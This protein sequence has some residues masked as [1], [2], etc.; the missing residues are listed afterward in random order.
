ML[1]GPGIIL[2]IFLTKFST[3]SRVKQEVK[4]SC[5]SYTTIQYKIQD[6]KAQPTPTPSVFS[7]YVLNI[8]LL[9]WVCAESEAFSELK[10]T[11][12]YGRNRV[13]K[14][15]WKIFSEIPGGSQ[16]DFSCLKSSFIF[17]FFAMSKETLH[18]SS[19]CHLLLWLT[20]D[21]PLWLL[22]D[23]S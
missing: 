14:L 6:I 18:L 11:L 9:T 21:V 2:Y 17:F 10:C 5:P 23:V 22:T 7:Q 20:A 16:T 3:V 15:K 4:L 12:Q 19:L 13:R 8:F 1:G